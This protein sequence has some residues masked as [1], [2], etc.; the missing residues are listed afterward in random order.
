[1]T[2]N[3]AGAVQ[4]EIDGVPASPAQLRAA[5]LGGYGHFT[6]MQVRGGRVRGF[7]RH[8]DR[9]DA[10]NREVFGTGIDAAALAGHIR[11]ALGDDIADASVRV[12]VQEADGSPSTMVTVRPPGSM[13]AGPW[14][15]RAVP[16]QRPLAHIK[17]TGDFGQRYYQRLAHASGFD[18]AL[19][20]GPDAIISEGTITNI[21]FFDGAEVVWPAAPALAGIT[22]QLLERALA[23]HGLSSRRGHVRLAEL[24]SFAAVFVTNARGI[25]PVGL[26]DDVALPVDD[27]F[28]ERLADA[29]ESVGWDRI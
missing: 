15:L 23:G 8:L 24:A 16:Y 6:A 13:P 9:L 28:M 5:A 19:L 25:A 20:T 18:E 2:T 17:H 22:M 27:G 7:D 29:Y 4:V 11:H 12:Y 14:K 21:G 3:P 1:M 10:A 26:V